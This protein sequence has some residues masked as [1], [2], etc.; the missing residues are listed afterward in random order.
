[1]FHNHRIGIITPRQDVPPFFSLY[2]TP[3]QQVQSMK[4]RST[5]SVRKASKTVANSP[6]ALASSLDDN[7]LVSLMNSDHNTSSQLTESDWHQFDS[8]MTELADSISQLKSETGSPKSASPGAEALQQH[9]SNN[10]NEEK[11]TDTVLYDVFTT[12]ASDS[13]DENSLPSLK[14][15][16]PH[17]TPR[18]CMIDNIQVESQPSDS[19]EFE[20]VDNSLAECLDEMLSLVKTTQRKV[21]S[22]KHQHSGSSIRSGVSSSSSSSG[23]SK[24]QANTIISS[25]KNKFSDLLAKMLGGLVAHCATVILDDIDKKTQLELHRPIVDVRSYTEHYRDDPNN[26]GQRLKTTF[27]SFVIPCDFKFTDTHD[28]VSQHPPL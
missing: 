22:L 24:A 16:L 4:P 8:F 26:P 12:N 3:T 27:F 9:Q 25:M 2:A 6:L 20:S 28:V 21:H 7:P 10:D 17:N 15:M 19:I 23:V 18:S 11:E 1:M 5:N 13:A 14:P